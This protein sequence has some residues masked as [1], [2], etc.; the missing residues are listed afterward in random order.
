M[1]QK[2]KQPRELKNI[3]YEVFI[4]LLSILSILNLVLR[5]C[6]RMRAWIRSCS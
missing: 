4:G 5:S 2:P 6:S 3:G 1:A